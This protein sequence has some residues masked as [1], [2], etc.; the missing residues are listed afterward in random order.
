MLYIIKI[1]VN[2]ILPPGCLI[3]FLLLYIVYHYKKNKRLPKLF[4]AITF[5][6]Y[7]ISIPLTSDLLT[8]SLEYKYPQPSKLSGDVVVVL[9]GGATLS[10][11][12]FSG[13][14][15]L[16]GSAANRLLTAARINKKTGLPIIFSGGQVFKTSGNEANI[17][18]RFLLD[19][20]ITKNDVI[21]ENKSLNTTENAKFT[22]VILTKNNYTKPILITSAFHMYRAVLNFNNSGIKNFVIYP[23]D[24]STNKN[25]SISFSSFIPS[26]SSL[27]YSTIALHEYLGIL[28]LL[29]KK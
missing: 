3:V 6:F 22:K 23:C 29:I 4:I 17:A 27:N 1:L 28:Q 2:I 26:G 18:K 5:L 20:G 25:I 10:S 7:I 21:I 14:G 24:Y 8:H 12:D 11:P 9:G 13:E 15:N 16:F 19:L